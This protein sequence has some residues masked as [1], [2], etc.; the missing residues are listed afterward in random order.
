PVKKSPRVTPV[1][2]EEKERRKHKKYIPIQDSEGESPQPSMQE[3]EET[4]IMSGDRAEATPSVEIH[5]DEDM[6]ER[7]V[8]ETIDPNVSIHKDISGEGESSIGGD[9][10][11]LM[12]PTQEEGK[13]EEDFNQ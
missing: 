12:H 4:P 7:I 9:T 11:V 3:V 8:Y 1:K 6:G 13:D 2:D 10:K 5:D